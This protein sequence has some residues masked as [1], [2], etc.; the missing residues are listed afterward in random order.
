MKWIRKVGLLFCLILPVAA[1]T[2]SGVT[3]ANAGLFTNTQ[4]NQKPLRL[5]PCAVL[6]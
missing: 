2:S 3:I 4:M 1:Q 6:R 5:S